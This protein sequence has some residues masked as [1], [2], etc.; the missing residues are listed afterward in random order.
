MAEPKLNDT[1]QWAFVG[2]VELDLLYH[3]SLADQNARNAFQTEI[4]DRAETDWILSFVFGP[5]SDFRKGKVTP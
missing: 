4:T 1:A 3:K 2:P 5:T